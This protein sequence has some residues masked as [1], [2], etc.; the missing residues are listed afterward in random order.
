[1]PPWRAALAVAA[2]AALLAPAL[3][4]QGPLRA[5]LDTQPA[6]ESSCC[7]RL[8]AIGFS[9]A[10]PVVIL[11][12]GG[13]K[14]PYKVDTPV[15]LCT[16]SPGGE[17]PDYS[18]PAE[19]AGRGSS[20]ANFAKKSFKVKTLG[21]DGRGADV[22]LLGMPADE[23]W[24]LYGPEADRTLGL[25]SSA[26]Y[27]LARGAGRYAARVVP[28]EVFLVDDGAPLGPQHYN[29]VYQSQEKIKRVSTHGCRPPA[30]PRLHSN[31]SLSLF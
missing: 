22:P 14:I 18:G 27:G 29:G 11:D 16:C 17:Y 6:P 28:C 23:D 19:A 21:P 12:T 25:R 10:L 7:A 30:A 4:Q 13:A 8:A 3:A 1:M 5:L 9:S 26:A 2:V 15:Q 31:P 24:I 20:S